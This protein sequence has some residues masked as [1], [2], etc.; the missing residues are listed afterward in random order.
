MV[1]AVAELATREYD[2][3]II[4][5]GIYGACAA[6]DAALRGLRVALVEQGD[7]AHATSAN[8]FRMVHGGIRYLQHADVARI[9][10]SSRDRSALLRIAPHL[11]APLPILIP[12]YGHGTRGRA[13]LAAGMRI[14][15]ALTADRNRAIRDPARRIPPGRMVGRRECLSLFPDL[16][17][18]GL[19]GGALFHD[20]QI[21][22]PPRLALAFLKAATRAGCDAANY[23]RVTGFLRSGDRIRGVTALD[24]LTGDPL[25]IRG[26]VVLNAAGP[27][28]E[29]LLATLPRLGAA[30]RRPFSRDACFIVPRRLTRR[31]ALAV[32][33]RT[34]D[35]DAILSRRARH[36][37]LV[38]WRDVTL[39]GVW[40]KVW[41][42]A[43]DD[44]GITTAELE[45]FI[46]EINAA[47]PPLRLTLDDVALCNTGLVLFG[48][49]EP[50]A[51]HLR[52]GKRSLIID[53]ARTDGLDGL[54]TVLG[55]RLTTARGVAERAVARVLE[56]LG[57]EPAASRTAELALPGGGIEDFEAFQAA[58]VAEHGA[59]LGRDVVIALGR[60]YGTECRRV[61]RLAREEPSLARPLPGS[62]VIGAEVVHAVRSEM[63]RKLGDVVFRRTELGTAR[64]PAPAAV[65]ECARLMAAELGWDRD[66]TVREI[67]EARWPYT[68][69]R[70]AARALAPA[71]PMRGA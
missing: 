20:A 71:T 50:G 36:L 40:H 65:A 43:P 61:I 57:R 13:L 42:G 23:V 18:K 16:Q 25:N 52:Y 51:T 48:E 59:R 45:A 10:E 27:W 4:G 14:Y 56:K 49:N 62:S 33:G 30:G 29:Y 38:P 11:V 37:F 54:V 58:L 5:G 69:D 53:H 60:N 9:R 66:R 3:V 21:Y 67:E 35:P 31:V 24:A 34:R 26:R 32:L 17:T 8:S 63:A 6:W 12:T 70:T 28:A 44:V 7:F 64:P 47:H 1:R 19:T 55:V 15:D 41:K 22:N 2:V 39:V 68:P 46:D